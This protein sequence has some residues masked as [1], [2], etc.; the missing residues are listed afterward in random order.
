MLDNEIHTQIAEAIVKERFKSTPF[1]RGRRIDWLQLEQDIR[2]ALKLKIDAV[3][4][5]FVIDI[6][7]GDHTKRGYELAFGAERPD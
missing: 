7:L 4:K 6:L 3:D 1:E 2:D 5:L